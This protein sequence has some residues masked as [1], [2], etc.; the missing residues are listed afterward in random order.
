MD[1]CV[2]GTMSG[3]CAS[4]V[5]PE[6]E[7]DRKEQKKSKH[8][9]DLAPVERSDHS[10]TKVSCIVRSR[11]DLY[12][13]GDWRHH[14]SVS[15]SVPKRT[16][17]FIERFL[18]LTTKQHVTRFGFRCH[19]YVAVNGRAAG[20]DRHRSI[21]DRITADRWTDVSKAWCW[22]KN[23]HQLVEPNETL[24]SSTW[25]S[26]QT[27]CTWLIWNLPST[28]VIRHPWNTAMATSTGLFIPWCCPSMIYEVFP[29]DDYHSGCLLCQ[30]Y[31]A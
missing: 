28:S 16:R 25:Y 7:W 18:F 15:F 6:E 1:E 17:N 13:R 23:S 31:S 12:R 2:T 8:F 27:F 3:C 29:C 30:L 22:N 4:K 26:S 9:R 5:I 10:A 19:F 11:R 14:R 21:R 20:A 24:R